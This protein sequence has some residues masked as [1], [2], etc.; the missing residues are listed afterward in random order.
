M[1]FFR[2]ALA[3]FSAI[4]LFSRSLEISLDEFHSLENSNE[5]TPIATTGQWNFLNVFLI[6]LFT[7][8]DHSAHADQ[9]S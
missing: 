3:F 2:N 8:L 1:D 5:V 7:V 9:V 4:S 6:P